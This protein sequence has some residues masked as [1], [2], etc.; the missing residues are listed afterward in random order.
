MPSKTNPVEEFVASLGGPRSF[1]RIRY[2]PGRIGLIRPSA[3]DSRRMLSTRGSITNRNAS[4]IRTMWLRSQMASSC[5]SICASRRQGRCIMLHAW[6]K[7]GDMSFMAILHLVSPGSLHAEVVGLTEAHGIFPDA[8]AESLRPLCPIESPHS[9]R[10][11]T[12][13]S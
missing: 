7:A 13:T 11:N 1:Y 8:I 5:S 2:R 4:R 3:M 10:S 9:A 6:P 12:A